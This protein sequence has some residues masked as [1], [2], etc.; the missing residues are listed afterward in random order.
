M[1]I[2]GV[3]R[4]AK[5]A[6]N[7]LLFMLVSVYEVT[8]SACSFAHAVGGS[9]HAASVAGGAASP[10]AGGRAEG[11]VVESGAGL[12]GVESSFAVAAGAEDG[13]R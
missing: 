3:S 11:R 2:Y 13:C 9:I 6:S 8:V 5:N 10:G 12:G 1:Y 7:R 4:N